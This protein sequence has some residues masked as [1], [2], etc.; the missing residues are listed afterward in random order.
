MLLD[1][2]RRVRVKRLQFIKGKK[3]SAKLPKTYF[4][5][6]TVLSNGGS[7]W[8]EIAALTIFHNQGYD[9]VWIDAF[10]HKFWINQQEKLLLED[11]PSKI[12]LILSDGTKGCWD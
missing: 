12:Q 9:G 8:P 3:L 7:V 5:K 11:L 6:L 4:S 1:Q 2:L 10:H